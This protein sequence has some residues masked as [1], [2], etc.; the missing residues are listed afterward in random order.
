M[1]K[2]YHLLIIVGMLTVVHACKSA[3]RDDS[4]LHAGML[5][6]ADIDAQRS[7]VSIY[8]YGLEDSTL[9]E[10]Y[11]KIGERDLRVRNAV[12]YY[13]TSDVAEEEDSAAVAKRAKSLTKRAVDFASF[14]EALDKD[15]GLLDFYND[16][17]AIHRPV[18]RDPES[19]DPKTLMLPSLELEGNPE[20]WEIMD[21]YFKLAA[22]FEHKKEGARICPASLPDKLDE[23][24]SIAR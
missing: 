8:Y 20:R 1:K 19:R 16:L 14:L 24:F 3:Q 11:I 15:Q 13:L 17:V 18:A 6:E 10:Y 7:A 4:Q 21:R 23:E 9:P 12:C 22:E 5:F 2:N